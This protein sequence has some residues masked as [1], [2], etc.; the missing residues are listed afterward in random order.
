MTTPSKMTLAQATAA[1]ERELRHKSIGLS[2]SGRRIGALRNRVAELSGSSFRGA[3]SVGDGTMIQKSAPSDAR[4][5]GAW[6]VTRGADL[7]L[8]G[9]VVDRTW[10]E[11]FDGRTWSVVAASEVKW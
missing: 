4:A 11:E 7:R 3:V 6:A 8:A 2:Y 5:A 10:V 1:L 9:N